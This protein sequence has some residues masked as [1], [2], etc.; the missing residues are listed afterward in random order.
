FWAVRGTVG[1]RVESDPT[2]LVDRW[3]YASVTFGFFDDLAGGGCTCG[4]AVGCGSG[5]GADRVAVCASGFCCRDRF[6]VE[7]S[8]GGGEDLVGGSVGSGVRHG[9]Y[10]G[11]GASAAGCVDVAFGP[12]T[13]P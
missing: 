11:L 9:A 8:A 5:A 1:V 3:S 7:F 12:G 4:G 13:Y 6:P 2:V 10:L